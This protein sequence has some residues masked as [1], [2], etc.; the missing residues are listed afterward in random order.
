MEATTE[1]NGRNNGCHH[2]HSDTRMVELLAHCSIAVRPQ[3]VTLIDNQLDPVC[4]KNVIESLHK[5][6][7][8]EMQLLESVRPMATQFNGDLIAELISNID[9]QRRWLVELFRVLTE[10]GRGSADP[11]GSNG[12]DLRQA[13][14]ELLAYAKAPG[15]SALIDE[16]CERHRH[17]NVPVPW[18]VLA[19]A[20][21]ALL[22]HSRHVDASPV[23][24][25]AWREFSTLSRASLLACARSESSPVDQ[26]AL[27]TA[28][29]DF[30]SWDLE[31]VADEVTDELIDAV[32]DCAGRQEPDEAIEWLTTISRMEGTAAAWR[33]L[34]QTCVDLHVAQR[35][36]TGLFAWEQELA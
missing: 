28:M 19:S 1:P 31:P 15:L 17:N 4:K 21:R 16:D 27:N 25:R 10:L 14:A 22:E 3:L 20:Q 12:S 32:I 29:R 26:S 6:A 2:M 36:A 30:L 34:R 9:Q 35:L 7:T 5:Q 8:E 24:D 23:L 13:I 18:Y 33:S 11:A